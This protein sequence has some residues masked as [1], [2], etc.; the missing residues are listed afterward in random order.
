[1]KSLHIFH[2][3]D[4]N[5]GV[6]RTCHTLLNALR[7]LGCETHILVPAE[8]PIT[9]ALS[10]DGF[11]WEMMP[12]SC[13]IGPAWRAQ[14]RFL[15]EAHVRARWLEDYLYRGRYDY[16]HL[17]T[18]HLLDAALA[19]TKVGVPVIWQIHTPFDVDYRRYQQFISQEG[20]AWILG[21]LGS[22]IIS[23]S[24]DNR[25]TML[26]HFHGDKIK[27]VHNGVDVEDV[28][29]RSEKSTGSIRQELGL[30]SESRLVLG[31]GR[32]SAQKDFACFVRVA[33]QVIAKKGDVFF[34]IAGP[35]ED[36]ILA[37]ALQEQVREASL[38]SKIFILGARGDVPSL[39]CQSNI[40]LSTSI[41][42]G[43]PVSTLEAMA[44]QCPV[45]AMACVGLRE[46]I[47][48]GLDGILTSLGDID[49]TADAVV[50]LLADSTLSSNLGAEAKK[51][52]INRFSNTKY[53]TDF[54]DV[55][56]D[57]IAYG[58]PRGQKGAVEVITG[59]L[60]EIDKARLRIDEMDVDRSLSRR[61]KDVVRSSFERS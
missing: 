44:L 17:N 27:V 55:V 38:T 5:N 30:P 12:L 51:T 33:Q 35:P 41:Y 58:P 46:C 50:K 47:A 59:L 8:G 15:G 21:E 2:N 56:R 16:I 43:H 57:A 9:D 1:M 39:M 40:F 60:G 31:V 10:E 49:A 23:V 11:K 48:D 4:L 22:L 32:I 52:I 54:L 20:Y 29:R 19:A 37:A 6:E 36:P 13:C 45:V 53:A 61:F 18:G 25:S 26:E 34:L 14:L 7:D 42:E 24:E 3:R 28:R